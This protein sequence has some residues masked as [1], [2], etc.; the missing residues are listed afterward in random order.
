METRRKILE[1]HDFASEEPFENFMDKK[2][3]FCGRMKFAKIAV[4]TA[5]TGNL[6]YPFF[7]PPG[8]KLF[9]PLFLLSAHSP[10]RVI[11]LH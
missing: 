10:Q 7:L 8:K 11:L 5:R 2:L 1:F 9:C 6:F 3:L 4:M